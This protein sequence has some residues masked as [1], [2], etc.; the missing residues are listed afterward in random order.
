MNNTSTTAAAP[1]AD[2]PKQTAL[3][4]ERWDILHWAKVT[5]RY[6]KK[7]EWF[8]NLCDLTTQ[9]ICTLAGVAVFAKFFTDVWIAGALVAVLSVLA[10]LVRYGDC[11]QRHIELAKRAQQLIG[12]IEKLPAADMK[13]IDVS[14]WTQVR[15]QINGD[16]P[17]SIKTL[18]ALCEWEQ[19]VE[20]G[21]PDHAPKLSLGQRL[22]R[23]FW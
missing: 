14:N 12:E 1:E 22:H 5:F 23:H 4:S 15:S 9:L 18:V 11:K 17:P 19:C 20:D 13:P 7:R 8:F 21:W 6:H 10:L 2:Q 16:E 3:E